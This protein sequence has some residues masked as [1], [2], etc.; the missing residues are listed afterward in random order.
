MEEIDDSIYFVVIWS[1]FTMNQN[2]DSKKILES[3][4]CSAVFIDA[5]NIY[6]S[7]ISDKFIV[8]GFSCDL[9]TNNKSKSMKVKI[10]FQWDFDINSNQSQIDWQNVLICLPIQVML[11]IHRWTRDMLL[12]YSRWKCEHKISHQNNFKK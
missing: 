12:P 3:Y 6:T 1:H 10:S 11:H 5:I 4:C 8:A 7:N 9:S 2:R